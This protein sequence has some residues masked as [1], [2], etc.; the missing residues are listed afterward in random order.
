MESF[1]DSDPGDACTIEF[2]NKPTPKKPICYSVNQV[3]YLQTLGNYTFAAHIES[4]E[5]LQKIIGLLKTPDST[6]INRLPAPWR[7]K[8]RCRSLDAKNYLY[9]DERLIIPMLFGAIIMKNLHYGH[10]G[11]DSMLATV[12][13]V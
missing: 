3:E 10:P 11:S 1:S 6:K 8:F 7:E 4:Y 12:S 2:A 5:F 13:N 9:M